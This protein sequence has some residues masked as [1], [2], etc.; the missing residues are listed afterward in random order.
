MWNFL[1]I[2]AAAAA[3]GAIGGFTARVL[4]SG[5]GKK[6]LSGAP[7]EAGAVASTFAGAAAGAASLLLSSA[8]DGIVLVGTEH[9]AG[10]ATLSVDQLVQCFGIG[11][12]G[13]KWLVTYQGSETLRS[14]LVAVAG[15]AAPNPAAAQQAASGAPREI[16]RA[17]EGAGA[18]PRDD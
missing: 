13:I 1:A 5:L 10:T 7:P 9:N 14:A 18:E 4:P 12:I 11:L 6:D 16:L 17:A 3:A 8:F 15:Q 2:L